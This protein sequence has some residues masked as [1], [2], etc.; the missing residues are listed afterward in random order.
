MVGHTVTSVTSDGV[1]VT[2]YEIWWKD[3]KSSGR[4]I[5]YKHA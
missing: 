4:M 2:G 1:M 5:L 3:V